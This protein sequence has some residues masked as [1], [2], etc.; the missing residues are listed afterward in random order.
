MHCISVN[1][2]DCSGPIKVAVEVLCVCVCVRACMRAC[3]RVR[4]ICLCL[5]LSLNAAGFLR[6]EAHWWN[7]VRSHS[8]VY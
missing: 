6:G 4:V 1:C 5:T 7:M 2:I 8:F 3:V